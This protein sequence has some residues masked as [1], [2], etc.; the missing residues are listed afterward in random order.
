MYSF[1]SH[2]F[3]RYNE[4]FPEYPMT[5]TLKDYVEMFCNT[6]KPFSIIDN[7]KRK[8]DYFT[9]I[10]YGETL[11]TIICDGDS[12]EIKTC[13]RETHKRKHFYENRFS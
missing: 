1:T 13:I 2:F 9:F 11:I 6:Q 4:R 5:D 8:S 12:N 7:K 10:L 3:E